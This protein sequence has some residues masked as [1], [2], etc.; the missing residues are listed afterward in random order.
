LEASTADYN[1]FQNILVML[2]IVRHD[3]L[4][5]L[6]RCVTLKLPNWCISI[7]KDMEA[8]TFGCWGHRD[9]KHAQSTSI[10]EKNL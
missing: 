10:D 9:K 7:P 5:P 4:F 2:E 8:A 1:N 3:F 6:L